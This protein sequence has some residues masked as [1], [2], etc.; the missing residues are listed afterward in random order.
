MVKNTKPESNTVSRGTKR[1]VFIVDDHPIVRK[2]LTQLINHENDLQ[3]CGEAADVSNAIPL[4][5]TTHPEAAIIDT[6]LGPLSGFKLI[7]NLCQQFPDL[8]VLVLSL[9]NE[10]L[11]AERCLRAGARGY[12]M[13]QAPP[14]RILMALRTVLDGEFYISNKLGPKLIN[15]LLSKSTGISSSSIEQLSN[16]ELEVF[17]FIGQGMKTSEMAESLNLSIKTIE[18]YIAHIK[19]KMDFKSSRE[20]FLYAVQWSIVDKKF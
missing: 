14:H 9:Y 11:Y 6:S 20:L 12:I 13:K 1:K 10:M 17:Q 16:R 5:K 3:L 7:E 19:K 8:P 18:T 15:K 4:I 2:G